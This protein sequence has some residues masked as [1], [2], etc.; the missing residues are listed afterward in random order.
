[1]VLVR[2]RCKCQ[3]EDVREGASAGERDRGEYKGVRESGGAKE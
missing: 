2:E 3:R 1:M